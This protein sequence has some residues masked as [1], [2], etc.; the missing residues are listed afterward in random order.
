VGG[1]QDLHEY[2]TLL[3]IKDN[4]V[5]AEQRKLTKQVVPGAI[6]LLGEQNPS[7]KPCNQATR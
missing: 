2:I 1:Q 5:L 3:L 4:T 6:A 7:V